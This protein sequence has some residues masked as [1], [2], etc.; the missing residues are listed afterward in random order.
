MFIYIYSLIEVLV[1]LVPILL[2][3][4]FITVIERKVIAA[5]QRR[6]GPNIVG[7]YGILQPF[8]DAA[9]LI[10][11]ETIVP[12]HANRVLLFLAPIVTLTF[13]LLGW[14]VIPLG[15]GLALA[16][17]SLGILYSIALSSVGILGILFA[18]WSSNSKY[19]FIGGLR[20]TSQIISY[21]LILT[22]VI[23]IVILMT[24]TFSYTNIIQHQQSVWFILPL[25]PLF[26]I[27]FFS[28]LAETNRTPFDLPEAFGLIILSFYNAEIFC[29]QQ[30]MPKDFI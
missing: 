13:S 19:A 25:L 17:L 6:V 9:K 12:N 8:A 28:A 10:L 14:V 30:L 16:D 5:I 21:E 18:G 27:W 23:L 15:Q 11:K 22:S 4:A 29:D 24:G 20:S 3:V 1:V 26:I 7:F 2:S